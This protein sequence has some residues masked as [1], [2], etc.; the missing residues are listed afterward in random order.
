M[1]YITTFRTEINPEILFQPKNEEDLMEFLKKVEKFYVIGGGSNVLILKSAEKTPFLLIKYPYFSKITL[2]DKFLTAGAG[3]P[4]T[5]FLNFCIKNE[6]KGFEF[7]AGIPGTI[8]G[9]TAMN[10]GFKG[11]KISD[12]ILKVKYATKEGIFEIPKERCKFGYRE[13]IFKNT[14]KVIIEVVFECEKGEKEV[15][16]RMINEIL[17][18]RRKKFP[19]DFP[20]A[21]CIFKNPEDNFAGRLIELAGC[22][23]LSIGDAEVSQKHANFIINKGKAKAEDIYKLIQIVK[24]KVK[25][26]FGIELKEEIVIFK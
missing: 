23:G 7:L 13:S 1:E 17:K 26:K 8:G 20:S 18:E 11:K 15:I 24:N 3:L 25:E 10:A 14:G 22:K 4:I 21:G 6:I 12:K 5:K 16:K 9:A 19:L 2:K